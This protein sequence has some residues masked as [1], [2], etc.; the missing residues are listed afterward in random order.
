MFPIAGLLLLAGCVDATPPPSVHDAAD[1]LFLDLVVIA[2]RDTLPTQTDAS[3]LSQVVNEIDKG[4]DACAKWKLHRMMTAGMPLVV[5][6]MIA[7]PSR[8]PRIR[9]EARQQ[10]QQASTIP[11]PEDLCH[12]HGF[13]S[14]T[15]D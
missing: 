8:Q 10:L 3:A 5:R 13:P 4:D 15:F 7:D 12:G 1:R 11:V 9:E 2:R 14:A 6:F